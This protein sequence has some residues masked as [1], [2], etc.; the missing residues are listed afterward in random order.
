MTQIVEE[1]Q[2]TSKH[3][4][5]DHHEYCDIVELKPCQTINVFVNHKGRLHQKGWINTRKVELT[6]KIQPDRG[7]AAAPKVGRLKPP[8]RPARSQPWPNIAGAP[9]WREGASDWAE[10]GSGSRRWHSERARDPAETRPPA[11][12]AGR[13]ASVKFSAVSH[14]QGPIGPGFPN[15]SVAQAGS[16]STGSWFS[17]RQGP[18]T[19]PSRWRRDMVAAQACRCGEDSRPQ[20]QRGARDLWQALGLSSGLRL[21]TRRFWSSHGEATE[22]AI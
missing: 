15:W 14:W 9:G 1:S 17:A 16:T 4:V 22:Q 6:L 13:R 5:A 21:Q 19:D 12:R 8:S 20:A 18:A 7:P 3:E 11:C 2:T 10:R